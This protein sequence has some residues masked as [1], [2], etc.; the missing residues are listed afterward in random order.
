MILKCGSQDWKLNNWIT[1][2]NIKTINIKYDSR[3]KTVFPKVDNI[4]ITQSA[5]NINFIL[6][7][8]SLTTKQQWHYV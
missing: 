3:A 2:M 7:Y 8:T 4:M 5:S 6:L 1:N